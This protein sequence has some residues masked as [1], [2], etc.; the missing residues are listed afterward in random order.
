[1]A[2]SM[3]TTASATPE[4]M[5]RLVVLRYIVVAIL[6][7]ALT[8]VQAGFKMDVPLLPVCTVLTVLALTN[9]LVHARL[10]M[11]WPVTEIEIFG[12]LIGD[13]VALTTLLHF[14]GGST[15]PLVSLYLFPLMVAATILSTRYN[16]GMAVITVACYSLLLFWY[17][18][19]GQQH[20]GEGVSDFNLHVLGMWAIFVISTGFISHFVAGMAHSLR[21]R[22]RMLALTREET[23]RNERIVALGTLAA[24]AAHELSTPLASMAL[25]SD[26]MAR[27]YAGQPGLSD[28]VAD[29]Q[30]QI[31]NC[32]VIISSLAD[33][34]GIARGESGQAQAADR[35]LDDVIAKWLLMRPTENVNYHWSAARP[36]PA[37][38]TEATLSQAVINLLNNAA[39]ASPG[40]VGILGRSEANRVIIEINDRGPGLSPEVAQRAG[41]AFFSTKSPGGL[42]IGLFLANATIERFGGKVRIFNREGGGACTEIELPSLALSNGV[43]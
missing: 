8:V 25:L 21:E 23:L 9:V 29:L 28:D 42:G 24:G 4:N 31:A 19:L 18:P 20:H 32:K 10:R 30:A 38:V 17:V 16:W 7:A 43:S 6:A 12:N 36:A 22:D 41:E 26:D 39:D 1:M 40:Q 2:K 14:A 5:R 35:F 11:R 3:T 13:V 27:R 34:A 33:S 15:N 37:I